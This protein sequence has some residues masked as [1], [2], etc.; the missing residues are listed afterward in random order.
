[1][2]YYN[3][4]LLNAL[5]EKLQK[6]DN[7]K[8]IEALKYYRQLRGL[9]SIFMDPILLKKNSQHKLIWQSLQDRLI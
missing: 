8:L 6:E 1:M 4:K 2:T 7:D 5:L 3:A 9:T